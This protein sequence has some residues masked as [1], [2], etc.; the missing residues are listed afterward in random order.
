MKQTFL[1]LADDAPSTEG[2]AV[3]AAATANDWVLVAS[4]QN[5]TIEV[6]KLQNT[7]FCIKVVAELNC[8]PETAF[9]ML[10]D[11]TKRGEWDDLCE[12]SGIV[13]I[14]DKATRVQFMKTK[15]VWPASP[16][17][18]LILAHVER[19]SDGRYLNVAQ[20]VEHS[21]YPPREAE[22]IVRMEAKISGQ[23]VGP[24]LDNKP[25]KCRVI[26]VNDGDL[27]GWIPKSVIGFIATKSIPNSFKKLDS[28]LRELDQITVSGMIAKAESDDEISDEPTPG[29]PFTPTMNNLMPLTVIT[30]PSAY[31]KSYPAA[32]RLVRRLRAFLD[33]WNPFLVTLYI[34]AKTYN[35]AR[36][37]IAN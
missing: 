1:D 5:P 19:L 11:I 12:E 34:F 25:G 21:R 15:G 20:S 18:T 17:D 10:A 13:E 33:W 31:Q 32:R 28:I 16:R 27:K 3:A 9:D 4:L 24:T 26:Q 30:S 37:R 2:A 6:Y 14:V 22:G 23:I 29:T 8:T 35:A 36:R 7:D